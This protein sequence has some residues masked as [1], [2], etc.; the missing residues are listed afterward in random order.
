MRYHSAFN[1]AIG[2]SLKVWN[3][4]DFIADASVARCVRPWTARTYAIP[5]K[6]FI[7]P[8]G[9]RLIRFFGLYASRSRRCSHPPKGWKRPQW[10][11]LA[12]HAPRGWK[13][14]RGV[15]D[16]KSSPPSSSSSV[17]ASSCRSAWAMLI[18][19][20]YEIDPQGGS[21]ASS[22]LRELPGLDPA[23]LN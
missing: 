14:A 20:V 2:D 23:S 10:D 8:Q 9:V 16:T 5:G 19:K 21:S 11:Y 4:R 22:A 6:R 7:P 1:P 12:R 13:Q 3:A 15:S 18:A 17:P